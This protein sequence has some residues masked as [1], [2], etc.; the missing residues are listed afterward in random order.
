MIDNKKALEAQAEAQKQQ[1]LEKAAAA[2]SAGAGIG[3]QVGDAAQSLQAAGL[4]PQAGTAA[5]L[6]G[7]VAA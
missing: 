3:Q 5:P 7:A 1:Q 6:E 4:V 2:V